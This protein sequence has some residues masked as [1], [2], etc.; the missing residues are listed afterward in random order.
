SWR[1]ALNDTWKQRA[2]IT[3]ADGST[4]GPTYDLTKGSLAALGLDD[5]DNGAL[6]AAVKKAIAVEPPPAQ[7][8]PLPEPVPKLPND[9][10]TRFVLR[11]V[12]QRARCLSLRPPLLSDPTDEF[13]IAGYFDPDA[14]SRPVRIALPPDA[15]IAALRKFHKNVGFI[16]SQKLRNQLKR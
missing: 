12:Y 13:A 16:T 11:C 3:E 5:A 2:L 1:A 10:D 14:P 15:G 8:P 6:I 7:A 9:P 4:Q